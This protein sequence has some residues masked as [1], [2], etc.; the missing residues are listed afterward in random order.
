MKYIVA[1]WKSHKNQHEAKAW[2]SELDELL[3]TR[4]QYSGYTLVVAV[5]FPFLS[6]AQEAIKT[7]QSFNQD[8]DQAAVPVKLAVQDISPF[9]AGSY[10][11]AVSARQLADFGVSFAVVGHSERRR[12]FTETSTD[13]AAKVARCLEANIT[14]IV[15]VDDPYLEEQALEIAAKDR[16]K[17]LVAYEALSAIGTGDPLDPHVFLQAKE[18]IET[19]FGTI[20]VLYGGSVESDNVS[21]YA[22]H[23]DGYLVGGASLNPVDFVAILD[24]LQ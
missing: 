19:A 9:D 15:C 17:I 23:A 16:S 21:E 20:P 18:E 1:N 22:D 2:F 4:Q 24:R 8:S 14:P 7:F 13:V 3:L 5:P 12:Y 10:T 6:V 11:G